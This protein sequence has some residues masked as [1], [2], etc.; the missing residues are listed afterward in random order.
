MSEKLGRYR[1]GVVPILHPAST[2][3]DDYW[4]N[5]KAAIKEQELQQDRRTKK[6][7]TFCSKG[8]IPNIARLK[9]NPDKQVW[10]HIPCLQQNR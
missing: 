8:N 5:K 10:Y 1:L 9:W 4:K 6:R 7:C 2:E 3:P